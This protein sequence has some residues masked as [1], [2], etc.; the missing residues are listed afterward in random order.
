MFDSFGRGHPH[1]ANVAA[2]VFRTVAPDYPGLAEFIEDNVL[3]VHSDAEALA[4]FSRW[5]RRSDEA[6]GAE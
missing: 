3:T 4:V 1:N 2:E 5:A 6:P